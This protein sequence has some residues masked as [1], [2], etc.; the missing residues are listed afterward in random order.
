MYLLDRL[1]SLPS[2]LGWERL[3]IS[4]QLILFT[5]KNLHCNNAYTLL[6]IQI[7]ELNTISLSPIYQYSPEYS[8]DFDRCILA[9]EV[10]ELFLEAQMP[11]LECNMQFIQQS[12]SLHLS[13][14]YSLGL[15]IAEVQCNFCLQCSAKNNDL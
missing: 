10:I 13:N 14:V 5:E 6:R 12:F 1:Q 7:S 15:I 8:L 4:Y 9:P 2:L 3:W 11:L